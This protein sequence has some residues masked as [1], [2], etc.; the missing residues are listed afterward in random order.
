MTLPRLYLP[1]MA[2]G[3]TA[4]QAKGKDLH[5]LKSVLRLSEGNEIRLFNGTGGQWRALVERYDDEGASLRLLEKD[6]PAVSALEITLAQSLPKADKM[7]FIVRK[8]TELGAGR[9]IPFISSRSVSGR[10]G[11]RREAGLWRW[12]RIAA[13]AARQSGRSVVPEITDILSFEMMLSRREAGVLGLFFWEDEKNR[14]LKSLLG[15]P[16]AREH[17]RFFIVVGPE[18]G[19]PRDEADQAMSG[20]FVAVTLGPY[21]LRTETAPLAILS[22]LQYE[23]GSFSERTCHE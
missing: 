10:D 17:S 4:V 3:E 16:S 20:G 23:K 14:F 19:F 2:D 8:G 13:E 22:I 7:D 12:P 18:G 5:Y 1:D 21:I 11:G 6:E 9:I 15:G